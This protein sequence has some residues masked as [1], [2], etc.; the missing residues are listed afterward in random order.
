MSAHDKLIVDYAQGD[1]IV[2]AQRTLSCRICPYPLFNTGRIG[3]FILREI[4]QHPCR[5]HALTQPKQRRNLIDRDSM[6]LYEPFCQ[7]STRRSRNKKSALIGLQKF[8]TSI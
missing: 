3:V 4:A 1:G 5:R 2:D 8:K 6:P 7:A